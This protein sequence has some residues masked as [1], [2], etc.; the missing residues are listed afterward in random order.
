MNRLLCTGYQWQCYKQIDGNLFNT[1]YD[2]L[3]GD[4]KKLINGKTDTLKRMAGVT[5]TMSLPSLGAYKS[6]ANHI[7]WTKTGNNYNT[8]CQDSI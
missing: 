2:Q 1:A 6:R 7:C 8:L 4:K 5:V 3:Q